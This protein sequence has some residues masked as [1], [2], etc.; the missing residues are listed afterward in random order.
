MARYDYHLYK[1]VFERYYYGKFIKT[2][3]YGTDAQI[4]SVKQKVND[5]ITKLMSIRRKQGYPELKHFSSRESAYKWVDRSSRIDEYNREYRMAP[6][7]DMVAM[8]NYKE[9]KDN[10]DYCS[11]DD[12]IIFN[13]KLSIIGFNFGD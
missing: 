1:M 5:M 13:G 3:L 2:M 6:V 10:A 12:F 7:N 4:E 9:I 11:Y 8:I